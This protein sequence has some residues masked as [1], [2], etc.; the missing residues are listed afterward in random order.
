MPSG[1]GQN[2]WMRNR[3]ALCAWALILIATLRIVSTWEVF[4][5]TNDEPDHIA[6]GM[7][8]LDRHTYTLVDEHP[9]LAR[10]STALGPYLLGIRSRGMAPNFTAEGW[11]ILQGQNQLDRN[12]KASR[13][14]IL[15]FFWISCAVV[16][17]GACRLLGSVGAV[18]ALFLWTNLPVVLAHGALATT[19]MAVT[20]MLGVAAIAAVRYLENP[21]LANAALLSL[22]AALALLCKFSAIPFLAFGL[23]GMLLWNS[24]L[25]GQLRFGHLWHL[26]AAVV[27]GSFVIWATYRFSFGPVRNAH[28]SAPAPEFISGLISLKKYND[29]G[30]PSY[31]LGQYSDTGFWSYYP[32]VL[33]FKTP[34]AYLGLVLTGIALCVSERRKPVGY[35]MAFSIGILTFAI[36]FSHINIGVRHILPAYLGV[37]V[38][39]AFAV[40]RMWRQRR[41]ALPAAALCLWFFAASTIAHPDYL[42]YFNELAGSQPEHILIDSDLDWG[43]DTKRLG[44]RLQ[45]L[46]VSNVHL[47]GIIPPNLAGVTFPLIDVFDMETPPSAGWYA[48]HI[49]A[50]NLHQHQ[51]LLVNPNAKFWTDSIAPAERVGRGVLLWHIH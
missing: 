23:L 21:R 35:A 4:N 20:A 46:K 43:Q 22:A 50:L 1:E 10:I 33:L 13:A 44:L 5:V 15:P 27:V 32:I 40:E 9:P 2:I 6:C 19:D 7:E 31:L 30:H 28:F 49:Q 16:F 29:H 26:L 14:G 11:A 12:L 18:L 3:F 51:R 47:A 34:L 37:T 8:W 45:Q 38:V 41:F 48:G 25:F 24:S 42:A 39:A 36:L 17:F